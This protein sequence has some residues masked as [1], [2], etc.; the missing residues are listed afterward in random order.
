M[1]IYIAEGTQQTGPFDLD[2]IKAGLREGRY[3]PTQL[4]WYE[5]AAGWEPISQLPGM[6]SFFE[7]P[8]PPPPPA[9][10][11]PPPYPTAAPVPYSPVP[12]PYPSASAP[13]GSYPPPPPF[14]PVSSSPYVPGP[15]SGPPKKGILATVGAVLLGVLAVLFG[16]AKVT[17][18]FWAHS[19]HTYSSSSASTPASTTATPA[20]QT[21]TKHFVT[22]RSKYTG[23][24]A[25]HFTSFSFDY[26]ETW[27][28]SE[29]GPEDFYVQA[30]QQIRRPDGKT[31]EGEFVTFSYAFNRPGYPLDKYLSVSGPQLLDMLSG[32]LAK[33]Y[34]QSTKAAPKTSTFGSYAAEE[35][36]VTAH[37]D[38]NQTTFLRLF[39]V[40]N[41]GSDSVDGLSVDLYGSDG[42]GTKSADSLGTSGGL[43]T[44][45]D[46]LRFEQ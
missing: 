12:P 43:K 1:Q 36:S 13:A 11:A 37:G 30:A 7:P 23:Q 29:E 28:I 22:Q 19:S 8:P 24:L 15:G 6:E 10:L 35:Q 9:P 34:P 3:L 20:P 26:P 41:R 45:M 32:S 46:S 2:M 21:P 39:I 16:I 14:V 33:Q 5:G 40:A 25:Q 31:V 42:A 44:I 17:R 38:S 4:A 27:Q 18:P